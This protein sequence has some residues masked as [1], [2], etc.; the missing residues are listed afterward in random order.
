MIRD[1]ETSQYDKR[2]VA[3]IMLSTG[4]TIEHASDWKPSHWEEVETRRMNLISEVRRQVAH[5]ERTYGLSG[6]VV[7]VYEETRHIQRVIETTTKAKFYSELQVG[8][9]SRG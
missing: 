3:Q 9:E 6:T 7:R 8:G 5:I 2:Y 1:V 4:A